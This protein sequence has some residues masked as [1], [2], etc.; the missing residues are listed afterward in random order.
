MW[1]VY[2]IHDG[3]GEFL[4]CECESTD[5]VAAVLRSLTLATVRQRR[6]IVVKWDPPADPPPPPLA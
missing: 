3:I 4:L 1:R 6:P 5:A 2:V